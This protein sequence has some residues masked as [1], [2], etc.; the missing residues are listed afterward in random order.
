MNKKPGVNRK[1]PP[2]DAEK[3]RRV[4][5]HSKGFVHPFMVSEELRQSR[6][7]IDTMERF[8]YDSERDEVDLL[9]EQTESMTADEKDDFWQNNF[10]VHWNEVFGIRIRS[11]FCTQVCSQVESTLSSIADNVRVL[12]RS[13]LS[14]KDIKG[15]TVLEQ[16]RLFLEA[17]GKFAGPSD[18]LWREVGYLFRVRNV[19]VHEQGYFGKYADDRK[20]VAF[21][22]KLPNVR[23]Q[24]DFIELQAGACPAFLDIAE[25][26]QTALFAEYQ[27]LRE[28]LIALEAS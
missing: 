27:A 25:R 9:K 26:F 5:L 21:L 7:F 17:F 16:L 13:P 19:H 20:F 24:S 10:P 4:T 11:A 2:L 28:R 1:R 15:S 12:A 23:I 14:F 18:L 3:A 22:E 6:F 8:I